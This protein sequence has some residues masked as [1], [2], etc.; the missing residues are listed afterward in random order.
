MQTNT[1][2]YEKAAQSMNIR[3]RYA[4]VARH[5]VWP[6][7]VNNNIQAE[8]AAVCARFANHSPSQHQHAVHYHKKVSR[9]CVCIFF[10]TDS[11]MQQRQ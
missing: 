5:V 6:M 1:R 7:I 8:I 3:L 10:C 9:N 11:R 4:D 2:V